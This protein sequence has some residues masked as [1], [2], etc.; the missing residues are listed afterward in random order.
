MQKPIDLSVN[1]GLAKGSDS[2][3]IIYLPHGRRVL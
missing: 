1:R 3:V 2:I